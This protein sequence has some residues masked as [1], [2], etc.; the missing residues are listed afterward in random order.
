MGADHDHETE[1]VS[2]SLPHDVV[3]DLEALARE[4]GITPS[5]LAQQAVESRLAERRRDREFRGRLTRIL[6]EDREILRRLA[7]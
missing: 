7:E 2:L 4:E 5:D 1:T 6:E 3:E